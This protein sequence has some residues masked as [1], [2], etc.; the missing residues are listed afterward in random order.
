MS[1]PL[2]VFAD[3]V[4]YIDVSLAEAG[5]AGDRSDYPTATGRLVGGMMVI[6]QTLAL[7]TAERAFDHIDD[8]PS[9]LLLDR[10][11]TGLCQDSIAE[12]FDNDCLEAAADLV[13]ED[14]WEN[15][16]FQE[17]FI[18]LAT[19]RWSSCPRARERMIDDTHAMRDVRDRFKDGYG[20]RRDTTIAEWCNEITDE[21]FI[22]EVLAL[23]AH[24]KQEHLR[25]VAA[26]RGDPNNP[27][28]EDSNTSQ[29]EKTDG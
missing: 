17:A 9:T 21:G 23:M 12:F 20:H 24:R 16:E 19:R 4:E 2:A 8:D 14:V 3:L 1:R 22:T 7:M 28:N 25:Q 15:S 18:A 6:R 13:H 11:S 10:I 27:A 5:E 29:Q 26:W